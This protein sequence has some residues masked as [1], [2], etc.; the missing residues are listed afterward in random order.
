MRKRAG[1]GVQKVPQNG[2]PRV[3]E[4]AAAGVRTTADF[5]RMMSAIMSDVIE[6]KITP[7][8]ANATVNAGGKML[9]C[10]EL[11]MKYGRNEKG[12]KTLILAGSGE[13]NDE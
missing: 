10:V 4:I 5:T 2:R 1:K 11:Q 9:K 13:G 7:A 12:T 3:L 8:T 6:G